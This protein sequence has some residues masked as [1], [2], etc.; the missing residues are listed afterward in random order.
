MWLGFAMVGCAV[1]APATVL[2]NWHGGVAMRR[3]GVDWGA[4]PFQV[5]CADCVNLS[6]R[7][8]GS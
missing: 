3:E 1:E 8:T 5:V 2:P 6:R 7:I 4:P